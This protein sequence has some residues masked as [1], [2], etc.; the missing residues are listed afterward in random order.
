MSSQFAVKFTIPVGFPEV[1][2]DFTR[3]VLRAINMD[4]TCGETE[5]DMYQFASEYFSD[6]ATSSATPNLSEVIN[7]N[8]VYLYACTLVARAA[9]PLIN[10]LNLTLQNEILGL[11]RRLFVEADVDNSGTIEAGELE[12]VRRFPHLL[13]LLPP[14]PQ[15][16][17]FV[18]E[19]RIVVIVQQMTAYH[20]T[21]TQGYE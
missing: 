7:Y 5:A 19:Y 16:Y 4:Q 1:L 2:K 20:K 17:G 8:C 13:L 9:S 10:T 15:S 12:Q 14:F 11:A 6:L 18:N 3:E 21:N